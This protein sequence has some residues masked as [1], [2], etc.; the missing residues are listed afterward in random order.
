MVTKEEAFTKCLQEGKPTEVC[1]REETA[2][3]VV[4]TKE[5][6]VPTP[7]KMV[8]ALMHRV[9]FG[10]AIAEIYGV[11]TKRMDVVIKAPKNIFDVKITKVTPETTYVQV[12]YKPIGR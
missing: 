6:G 10:T 9:Q 2:L 5:A 12:A 7:P 4:W 3:G 1:L 11:D 8:P